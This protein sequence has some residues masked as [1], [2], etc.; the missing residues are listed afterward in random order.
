[1]FCSECGTKVNEGAKFCFN[2]GAKI[3][4]TVP[5]T[6][7]ISKVE[8]E[9]P[10]EFVFYIERNYIKSYVG[11]KKVTPDIFYKKAKFYEV[12]DSQVDRVVSECEAKISKLEKFI[13][14]VYEECTLF[15]LAEDEEEEI[16]SFGNSL[17][18]D[19][20][21]IE[22]L[23]SYYDELNHI[24]EK[25]ELYSEC[26][27]N[28]VR[29]GKNYIERSDKVEEY[30]EEV[31]QAFEKNILQMEA[32]LKREYE[33]SKEYELNQE[34]LDFIYS[35]GGKLIPEDAIVGIIYSYDKKTGILQIK[36]ER[37]R[38]KALERMTIFELYGEQVAY[39]EEECVGIKI[40]KSYRKVFQQI[41]D[42]FLKFYDNNDCTK[43]GYWDAANKRI[44]F[45]IDTVYKAMCSTLEN[46]G[47][48]Q[49]DIAS[50]NYMDVFQFW[51]PVFEDIDY[52]YN[53]ICN[54]TEAAEYYRKI[55]KA[56]RGRLVGGGFGLD[57]AVKGIATAGAINMMTGAAHSAFNFV[58]NIKSEWK[59]LQSI[60]EIFGYSM[61]EKVQIVFKNTLQ[62]A[63]LTELQT[64]K[65]YNISSKSF[66]LFYEKDES[67]KKV[68]VKSLQY[69][70]FDESLYENIIMTF[71]IDKDIDKLA[72]FT[73]IEIGDVK[74]RRKQKEQE[75]RTED[76]IIFSTVAQKEAYCK[77]R[78]I[79]K[80]VLEEIKNINIWVEEK[81]FIERID[82]LKQMKIPTVEYWNNQRNDILEWSS[83]LLKVIQTPNKLYL[84][85]ILR[86]CVNDSVKD[87]IIC[88]GDDN[89]DPMLNYFSKIIRFDND[90]RIVLFITSYK[91]EPKHA[92]IFGIKNI[93]HYR[94]ERY[95]QFDYQELCNV[96]Y[97]TEK[98]IILNDEVTCLEIAFLNDN[99]IDITSLFSTRGDSN[100]QVK[101]IFVIAMKKCVEIANK[102]RSNNDDSKASVD[103]KSNETAKVK[104]ISHGVD[105]DSVQANED[106]YSVE[107]IKK[108]AK[109]K[110]KNT[111]SDSL[112]EMLKIIPEIRKPVDDALSRDNVSFVWEEV[113]KKNVYAEYALEEYY[114]FKCE[115]CINDYDVTGMNKIISEVISRTEQ[116]EIFALYLQRYLE[117]NMYTRN[118]RD[119]YSAE[120]AA[121]AILDIADIG[122]VSAVTMKGFWGIKGYHNATT[123]KTEGM[124]YLQKAAKD[125]S[126][127]AL[128]WLGD[129]YKNGNCG[130]TTDREKAKYY[131]SLAA[132][133]GQIY[134][135]NQLKEINNASASSSSCFIT[136]AVCNSFGKPDD[137]Y[138][139]TSFRNYRDNWL[140]KQTF[141]EQLIKEYYS[142][143]PAIVKTI[144]SRDDSAL[145]Y[146]KIWD[147][148]LKECLNHIEKEQ[149]EECKELYIK[150][151]RDMETQYMND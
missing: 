48:S 112:N 135:K 95:F 12:V 109:A 52:K 37:E 144:D 40:G 16:I 41:N 104:A 85:N 44:L 139:L 133:Y 32:L 125:F 33:N 14:S 20:E 4:G 26:V 46:K 151:V 126:P 114:K 117:F 56:T 65:E 103:L 64:L 127:T 97:E 66:Q 118:Q 120:E 84:S 3:I 75:E 29:D 98:G 74:A 121:E 22:T 59:K 73:E 143:A 13:D 86:V 130:L 145:I 150:M 78:E 90:E 69:N 60:K 89:Y 43:D 106:S 62:W 36:E 138:E 21:D 147:Q 11:G 7:K 140:I 108:M 39:T 25:Q 83:E 72:K 111:L 71:G 1:M 82:A 142:V 31:Y 9:I 131:F 17:G 116:G 42:E 102:N 24:E 2:C 28:Y 107:L 61:K 67:V 148:Y 96:K 80:P 5:E 76:G 113:N 141:G 10:E 58:G 8:K 99:V 119:T 53:V 87:T 23:M 115:K 128:A 105:T 124:K 38:Q 50:I 55:R 100:Y 54:G 110:E 101:D 19:D 49:E 123:T 146:K 70:P 129:C 63:Y 77:E 92:L 18:F 27:L 30:Q 79:Y 68:N 93:Y 122:N 94:F 134:G 91:Q 47:V 136:T 35:E 34:Q 57:G 132:E 6:N 149:F 137:C 81:K 45:L 15:E 88:E 51:I